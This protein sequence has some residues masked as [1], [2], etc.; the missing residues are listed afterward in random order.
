[1]NENLLLGPRGTEIIHSNESLRLK[2]Y[3]DSGGVWTIGWGHTKGVKPGSEINIFEADRLFKQDVAHV[4]RAIHNMVDVDLSQ[5]QFDALVSFAYNVGTGALHNSTLLRVLN[6]GK[7]K[8]AADELLRWDKVNGKVL[9]GLARRR[10]E[11]RRLF[12]EGT[13]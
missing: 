6:Q 11:E 13:T 4:E 10:R 5:E 1:M 9:S 12:L 8:L 3:R 2:A 7:Y